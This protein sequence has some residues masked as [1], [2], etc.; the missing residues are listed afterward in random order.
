MA[1]C[2]VADSKIDWNAQIRRRYGREYGERLP[3]DR[4]S[5]ILLAA[6]L[7]RV[8]ASA[9]YAGDDAYRALELLFDDLRSIEDDYERAFLGSRLHERERTG[10]P[11]DSADGEPWCAG[12]AP[13]PRWIARVRLI[14]KR[15]RPLQADIL[16]LCGLDDFVDRSRLPAL[17]NG[18]AA[19]DVA[20]GEVVTLELPA[21]LDDTHVVGRLGVHINPWI[22]ALRYTA[23]RRE[24]D[25]PDRFPS[26]D[27]WLAK[28]NEG[29]MGRLTCLGKLSLVVEHIARET[30]CE[31]WEALTYLLC[32]ELP[33][34]TWVRA[35]RVMRPATGETYVV[36]VGASNVPAEDVR[37]AYLEARGTLSAG[38]RGPEVHPSSTQVDLYEFVRPLRGQGIPWSEIR[39]AWNARPGVKP[40]E[41]T[42]TLEVAYLRARNR[43]EAAAHAKSGRSAPQPLQ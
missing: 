41:K 4:V 28:E 30:G 10:V 37:R 11:T 7:E 15:Y 23:E 12:P 6:Q 17:L 24:A 27:T 39:E 38:P 29:L 18:L 34:L 31:R 13:P 43:V 8:S 9:R 36:E 35:R 20:E 25:D 42:R 32:G 3:K 40:Y 14:M 21:G 1:R 26:F 19:G 22:S 2:N 5:D 33:D 16:G